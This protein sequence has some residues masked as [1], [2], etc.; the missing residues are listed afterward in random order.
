M[1][2]LIAIMLAQQHHL[3][4]LAERSTKIRRGA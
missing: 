1:H 4:L 2:P 3:E